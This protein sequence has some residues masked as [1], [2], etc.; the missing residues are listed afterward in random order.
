MIARRVSN[1]IAALRGHDPRQLAVRRVHAKYDAALTNYQNRKHWSNTDSY[2]AIAALRPSVRKTIRERAR[3]ELGSNSYARGLAMVVADAVVGKGPRLQ[4]DTGNDDNDRAVQDL[5]EQWAS[6]RDLANKLRT[7]KL[8]E[9]GDGEAFGLL[10]MNPNAPGDLQLDLR[11]IETDQVASQYGDATTL[12]L[13]AEHDD[14]IEYDSFGNPLRYRVLR[15]HPGD[16]DVARYLNDYDMIPARSMLHLYAVERP[17]Q[18]RGLPQLTA[19]LPLFAMLRR[20]TLAVL[21]A[22][23]NA[24]AIGGVVQTDAAGVDPDDV[25][26]LDEFDLEHGSWWTLPRGWRAMQ[27]KSEQPTT[28]FGDFEVRILK[29]ICRCAGVPYNVAFADSSDSNFSSAKLDTLAWQKRIEIDRRNFVA[30][31]LDPLFRA[32]LDEA[33]LVSGYL[34]QALRTRQ[35]R[36]KTTWH[37]DA[38]GSIDEV[39]SASANKIKLATGELTYR[40][41]H[42]ANG[43]DWAAQ[44]EQQAKER[45]KRRELGLVESEATV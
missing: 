11:P 27:I 6:D 19:A 22:A 25:V 34:P 18:R 16:Y 3:Y 23:E 31:V 2:S 39:K 10:A 36:A 32:W 26:P 44:F 28:V 40:D 4:V 41:M 29:Q 42:A 33:Q 35:A 24:A 15:R 12:A 37:F 30:R 7:L 17:G 5:F 9:V 1:A 14:G 45:D 21:L 20:Y 13:S 8:A 43:K 38:Y